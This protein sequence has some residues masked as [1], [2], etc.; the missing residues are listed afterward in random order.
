[1]NHQGTVHDV[2]RPRSNVQ[3][4]AS[5]L[6]SWILFL[7]LGMHC[8]RETGHRRWT[9][10]LGRWTFLVVLL[11]LLSGRELSSNDVGVKLLA[12]EV[13]NKGWIVFSARE[14]KNDWDLFLMRPDGSNRRNV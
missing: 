5:G 4:L 10:D 7:D 12:K 14:A 2:Q 13:G 6:K 11:F 9:L 1:M 3:D 8:R